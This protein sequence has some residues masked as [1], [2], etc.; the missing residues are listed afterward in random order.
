MPRTRQTIP[1]R[2]TAHLSTT[3]PPPSTAGRVR[4]GV[5]QMFSGRSSVGTQS[6]TPESPKTPRLA[7]ALNNPSSTTTPSSHAVS[8]LSQSATDT[9]IP[10]T[11]QPAAPGPVRHQQTYHDIS[12]LSVQTRHQTPRRFVDPGEHQLAELANEARRRRHKTQGGERRR[13]PRAK[14]PKL[15]AKILTCFVSGVVS[16]QVKSTIY[17]HYL[18]RLGPT[19]H[20]SPLSRLSPVAARCDS[21]IPRPANSDSPGRSCGVLPLSNPSRPRAAQSAEATGS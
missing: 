18:S 12:V 10:A 19:C 7:L 21:G 13:S 14:K 1:R 9:G 15:R 6:P 11:P 2:S 3:R 5:Q 8:P 17:I 16:G 4:T 20:S